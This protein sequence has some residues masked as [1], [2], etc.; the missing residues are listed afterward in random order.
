M[1][2]L[3][4]ALRRAL[5]REEPP[6]GFA[7]RVVHRASAPAPVRRTGTAAVVVRW[8]V[9]AVVV[10]AIAGGVEYRSVQRAR[11]ERARGEAAK[12]QALQAL[13]IASSK[14]QLVQ[15]KI[16]GIGS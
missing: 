15:A 12:Q 1:T 5:G 4:D 11:E 9:A 10:A 14:L 13:S 8:A 7:E 3:D 6:A 2:E 16:K